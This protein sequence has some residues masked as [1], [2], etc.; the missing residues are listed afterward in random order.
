MSFPLQQEGLETRQLLSLLHNFRPTL[1]V[2][3]S[4][5]ITRHGRGEF[6]VRQPAVI[7]VKGTA[8]S[9]GGFGVTVAIYAEDSRGQILNGGQPPAT[10]VPDQLGLY[11]AS[12]RLPSPIRKGTNTLAAIETATGVI[13][14]N[15]AINAT[16][17]SGLNSGLTVNVTL[18][19]N[20]DTIT[21]LTATVAN[22]NGTITNLSGPISIDA[23]TTFGGITGA[24]ATPSGTSLTLTDGSITTAGGT[25]SALTG[26]LSVPAGTSITVGATPAAPDERVGHDS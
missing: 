11:R 25:I 13:S 9:A 20:A 23:G 18:T 5:G 22:F 16:S 8:Q 12:I 10:A 7:R 14:S 6:V 17:L 19:L 15:L 26:T 21:N 1:Q 4:R 3:T 24:V 2:E